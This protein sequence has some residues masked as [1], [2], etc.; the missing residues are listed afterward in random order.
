MSENIRNERLE[1]SEKKFRS[2]RSEKS[3]KSQKKDYSQKKEKELSTNKFIIP[4]SMKQENILN[5]NLSPF[6]EGTDFISLMQ[7]LKGKLLNKNEDWTLHLAVVNYLRRLLKFEID[8]FNQFLFGLK[9]YPKII[10][11]INSIRSKL[12]KNTLILV[13]EIFSFYVP[14]YDEKKNKAPV[15]TLIKA[16]IPTLIMKANCNQS[17]I[18]TE[19]NIC[20]ESLIK[21]MKYGDTLISLIQAMSTKNNKEIELAYNLAV[22]LCNNLSNEYIGEFPLFSDLMKTCGNIYDLKKDIY[23]KKIII[24]IKLIRDKLTENEFNSKLEKCQKKERELI[25]KALDPNINNKPK[26]K[27]ESDFHNFIKK[28]KDNLK[29]KNNQMK[30]NSTASILVK[31][32]TENSA[33][34]NKI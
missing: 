20:L 33:K 24:L 26:N 29:N 5:E 34:K 7:H 14:E 23:V 8:I 19:A 4:D 15:I 18:K 11:L 9:L 3:Q 16:L 1:K 17:F 30:R 12:A 2:E 32:K 6:E 28:S 13:N 25:K 10:E 31:N 21:N 22:K 27:R